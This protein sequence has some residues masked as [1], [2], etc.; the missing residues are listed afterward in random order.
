M[1]EI[2]RADALPFGSLYTLDG[3]K[4]KKGCRVVVVVVFFYREV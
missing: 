3:E 2:G 4:K 1:M